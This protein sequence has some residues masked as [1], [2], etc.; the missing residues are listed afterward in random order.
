MDSIAPV[1][2]ELFISALKYLI[3]F[4]MLSI[5]LVSMLTRR[6]PPQHPYFAS[7]DRISVKSI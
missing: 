6:L 4:L 3:T 1:P 2:E 5:V 7:F